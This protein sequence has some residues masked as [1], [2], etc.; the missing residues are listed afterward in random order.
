MSTPLLNLLVFFL[1][2]LSLIAGWHYGRG[3]LRVLRRNREFKARVL[4]EDLLKHLLESRL[5]ASPLPKEQL[6][7]ALRIDEHEL[8]DVTQDLEAHG[9]LEADL[10]LTS[11]GQTYALRIMRAHRLYER[12]L[13]EET[14]YGEQEWHRYADEREHDL[15]EQDIAGLARKLGNPTHDPHG[16]PIPAQDGFVTYH[17]NSHAL[18]GLVPGQLVR[19]VHVE[20]EPE[21]LY[22][23][24]VA[25]GLASGQY[26]R[27]LHA[28]DQHVRLSCE[29]REVRLSYRAAENVTVVADLREDEHAVP[30]HGVTLSSLQPGQHA[31]VISLS[32]RLRGSE[33]RRLLDLGLLPGTDISAELRSPGGDPVAYDIRGSLIALRRKQADLILVE[34]PA[35]DNGPGTSNVIESNNES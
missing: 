33:R 21:A 11:A 3:F 28:D 14:G 12:Y 35:D 34:P 20:D 22:A 29:G 8:R 27:V 32:Q 2:A 18:A 10:Q 23:E 6:L 26:V 7:R 25:A 1:L 13:A 30:E 15:T 19:I 31:R 5:S 4:R 9:M 24:L 16:D 17:E